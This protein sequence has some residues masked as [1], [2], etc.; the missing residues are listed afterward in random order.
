MCAK[1]YKNQE[2]E[3]G[4]IKTARGREEMRITTR[5]TYRCYG[6]RQSPAHAKPQPQ[7]PSRGQEGTRPPQL[8]PLRA[9]RDGWRRRKRRK[10]WPW[11]WCGCVGKVL[12]DPT[13]TPVWPRVLSLPLAGVAFRARPRRQASY[14]RGESDCECAWSGWVSGHAVSCGGTCGWVGSLISPSPRS[15]FDASNPSPAYA[16]LSARAPPLT[17]TGPAQ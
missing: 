16:Y 13:I 7:T 6:R 17:T 5:G 8:R 15:F 9:S 14:E 10:R 2:N 11:W 12:P 1:R 4:V 3:L